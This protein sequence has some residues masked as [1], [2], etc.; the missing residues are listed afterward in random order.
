MKHK[1]VTEKEFNRVKK[2]AEKIFERIKESIDKEPKI[3]TMNLTEVGMDYGRVVEIVN[4]LQ[5]KLDNIEKRL[6][7]L[8]LLSGVFSILPELTEYNK[9][10][11]NKL[12]EMEKR[13]KKIE[14]TCLET[15]NSLG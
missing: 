4:N 5:N 13:L 14:E 2:D 10:A 7:S 12:E 9:S 1:K 15:K 11:V 8:E 6:D 3:T